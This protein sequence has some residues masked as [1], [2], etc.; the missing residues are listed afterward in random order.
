MLCGLKQSQ[1]M[2]LGTSEEI[3]N[4]CRSTGYTAQ[5][6]ATEVSWCF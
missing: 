1:K 2:K 3:R 5:V 6:T 4:P